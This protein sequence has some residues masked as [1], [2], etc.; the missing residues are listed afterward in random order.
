MLDRKI[1][2][3]FYIIISMWGASGDSQLFDKKEI[4]K[5]GWRFFYSQNSSGSF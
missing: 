2:P 1:V 5:N 4:Y 3:F